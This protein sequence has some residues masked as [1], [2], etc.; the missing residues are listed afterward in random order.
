MSVK[1]ES[2]GLATVPILLSEEHIG[3]AVRKDDAQLL[4]RA[5]A[6]LKKARVD[7]RFKAVIERWLPQVE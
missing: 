3:R 1:N 4:S 2:K 7:G 6:F 5:N